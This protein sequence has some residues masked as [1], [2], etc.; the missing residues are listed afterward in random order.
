MCILTENSSSFNQEAKREDWK[1]GRKGM[2]ASARFSVR[3]LYGASRILGGG[4]RHNEQ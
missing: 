4:G 3:P 1:G 2:H